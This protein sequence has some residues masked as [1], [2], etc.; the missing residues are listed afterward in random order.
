MAIYN[1]DKEKQD[2][3]SA[4]YELMLSVLSGSGGN[5]DLSAPRL[6]LIGS[7]KLKIDELQPQGEGVQ[8]IDINNVDVSNVLDLYING[9]LDESA[10]NVLQ[11]APLHII[12]PTDGAS[13]SVVDNGDGTGYIILP[14][15][16][17]RFMAFKMNTWYQEVTMPITTTDP[18][19]KL[20]KYAATRG[21]IAKPIVALNSIKVTNVPVAQVDT[22]TL[23]GTNGKANLICAGITREMIF[24]SSLAQTATDF[25]TAY[26]ADFSAQGV[27]ISSNSGNII[28]TAQVAGTPFASP[29]VATTE[30]NLS[31][32]T[33]NTIP[34][35]PAIEGKRTLEYYSL[36][37]GETHVLNKFLYVGLAGAEY[38]QDN[39]HEAL[40]WM[41]ASKVLQVMGDITNQGGHSEKALEQVKLQFL[42]LM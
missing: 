6:T 3:T 11:T 10:R 33:A 36:P 19:Y 16:Y 34:N 39:L 38:I 32:A 8:F 15:D 5:L 22:V 27:D 29:Y 30:G 23:S 37:S 21:G 2:Y 24:N 28:F 20:Q 12:I 4:F 42:N 1:F 25:V 35:V 14:D 18:M 41:C 26:T 31:G 9:L 17:L 13:Q 7:V 40:S